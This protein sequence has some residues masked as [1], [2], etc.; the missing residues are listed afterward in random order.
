MCRTLE[1]EL[2]ATVGELQQ[3][4]QS[5]MEHCAVAHSTPVSLY[6]KVTLSVSEQQR[7]YTVWLRQYAQAA[8]RR[9][10]RSADAAVVR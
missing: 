5:L 2:A 3:M 10:A 8:R 1:Q 9:T 6:P 7:T 4:N